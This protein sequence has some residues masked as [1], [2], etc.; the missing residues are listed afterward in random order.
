MLVR[1]IDVS[2]TGIDVPTLIVASTMVDA[3]ERRLRAGPLAAVAAV[4]QPHVTYTDCQRVLDA[5]R[6]H[7]R[8]LGAD[9]HVFRRQFE[10]FADTI[11]PGAQQARANAHDG[12]WA[13]RALV[14]IGR[15]LGTGD[16]VRLA[17]VVG[18]V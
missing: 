5:D 2:A 15:S 7:Q 4:H 3:G 13:V 6:T 17:D 10:D 16:A 1:P 12:L 14:A 18:A 11:L 9:S 8:P